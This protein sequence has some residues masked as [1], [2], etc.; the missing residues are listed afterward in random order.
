MQDKEKDSFLLHSTDD[1]DY[2]LSTNLRYFSDFK[3][4]ISIPAR[5]QGSDL[6]NADGDK[7]IMIAAAVARSSIWNFSSSLSHVVLNGSL[8]HILNVKLYIHKRSG[9]WYLA[10]RLFGSVTICISERVMPTESK[11]TPNEETPKIDLF[12]DDDEFEEFEV[13]EGAKSGEKTERLLDL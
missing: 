10:C 1:L 3:L 11:V 8:Y 13:N 12:E 9:N 5:R 7:N 6:L 2:S 4:G